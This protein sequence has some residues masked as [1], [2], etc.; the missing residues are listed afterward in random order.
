[1]P[2]SKQF[3]PMKPMLVVTSFN[4]QTFVE[5]QLCAGQSSTAAE[6]G[7]LESWPPRTC[8]LEEEA[9]QEGHTLD[10]ALRGKPPGSLGRRDKWTPSEDKD[11]TQ[12]PS[13][14]RPLFFSSVVSEMPIKAESFWGDLPPLAS[15]EPWSEQGCWTAAWDRGDG[16]ARQ[17]GLLSPGSS[18]L[19]APEGRSL[20]ISASGVPGGASGA[21][22]PPELH[23]GGCRAR[24]PGK[25][26]G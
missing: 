19:R 24:S 7:R 11:Q 6:P 9:G 14:L 12:P 26:G 20:N 16:G 2:R 3:S 4:W 25:W 5:Q 13:S 15:P 1:M 10:A 18:P 17:K 23:P 21:P 8:H 22:A